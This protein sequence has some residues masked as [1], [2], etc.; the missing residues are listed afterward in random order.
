MAELRWNPMLGQWVIVA[1]HREKRPQRPEGWCP[2]CPGSGKVPDTYDVYAYSNDYP[3]LMEQPPEPECESTHLYPVERLKGATEVILYSPQ[4]DLSLAD[5]SPEH[6]V[7]L[8]Q[9]WQERYAS[10]GAREYISYVLIFENKGEVIGVTIPHPHGQIYAYPFIPPRPFRELQSEKGYLV[11]H[12]GCLGCEI[13]QTELK[14][15]QRVIWETDDCAAFVPFFA[16]YPYEVHIY[17]KRH[18]QSL[19]HLTVEEMRSF[20]AVLKTIVRK[21]DNLFGFSFPYMMIL[22][23]QPTDGYDHPYHHF[24]IEFYPPLMDD[25]NIRYIAGS[26]TGSGIQVNPTN[27]EARARQLQETE[28]KTTC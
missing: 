12:G 28:P 27:I 24:R 5:L 2:F 19:L 15:G 13:L 26:E 3:S 8:M 7:K 11:D 6:V 25:T 4:H 1:A 14:H 21:Y 9:L 10:L 20:A 22:N 16:S 23:Q 18:L 17:P